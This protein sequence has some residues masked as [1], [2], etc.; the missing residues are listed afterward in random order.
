MNSSQQLKV[1]YI[2]SSATQYDDNAD[3]INIDFK[4]K[5]ENDLKIG[6][7]YLG[8]RHSASFLQLRSRKCKRVVNCDKEI[9]GLSR[10]ED[11]K[12]LNL[13]LTN[14]KAS[15][16]DDAFDFINA[17]LRN[18]K[19]VT[20]LCGSGNS[21]AA[22]IVVYYIMRKKLITQLQSVETVKS[23]RNKIR[24]RPELTT[25]ILKEEK[26]LLPLIQAK[27]TSNSNII[28]IIIGVLIF[29][30]LLFGGIYAVTGKL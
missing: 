22:A 27:R 2:D 29:F 23:F 21:K 6:K 15:D 1:T 24:I 28:Y 13:D 9:H 11:V 14:K 20:V 26:K 16:F 25:M 19:N 17:N 30:G 5:G 3:L 4:E 18:G 7:L 10:E 12:Y 8:D